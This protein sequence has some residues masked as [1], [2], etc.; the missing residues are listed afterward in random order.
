MTTADGDRAGAGRLDGGFTHRTLRH[1]LRGAKKEDRDAA[2]RAIARSP[3]WLSILPA[4]IGIPVSGR[5][6]LV[7]PLDYISIAMGSLPRDPLEQLLVDGDVQL[8]H[9]EQGV[10]LNGHEMSHQASKGALVEL[11]PAVIRGDLFV[12]GVQGLRSV[13]V[14]VTG[15]TKLTNIPALRE[16]KGE[17]F[18]GCV[19]RGTGLIRIGADFRC[20]GDL[21]IFHHPYL[22]T[23]NCEVGGE[24]T[25]I[26]GALESTGPAFR[27]VGGTRFAGSQRIR[28]T[29]RKAGDAIPT[30]RAERGEGGM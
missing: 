30:N 16:L 10:L 27:A 28:E 5:G 11:P 2:I 17:V 24:L 23:L 22:A 6:R 26:G 7:T 13:N 19:L 29:N 18:C 4:V 25:V 1:L 3:E 14:R 8:V 15:T 21:S 9:D 20:A 12:S